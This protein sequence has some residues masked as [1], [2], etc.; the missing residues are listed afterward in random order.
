[1]IEVIVTGKPLDIGEVY[2][3][4][5]RK[6]AGAVNLF[7][8]TIRNKTQ[9][10]DVIRLEYEAYE[11]MAVKEME[12]IVTAAADKWPVQN[13]II[14]HR[15]GTLKIGEAAVIIGVS[16]PHRKESFDACQFIIDNLKQTVPIWKKEVFRD[17][18]E[19]VS[20]HP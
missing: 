5:S 10:K 14:H 18:E 4:V 16:T 20:A 8:G 7:V 1:M 19:W 2:S 12:K 11:K 9:S 13:V 3:K 6:E 15:Q 17:G